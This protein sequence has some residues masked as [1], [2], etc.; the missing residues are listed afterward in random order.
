MPTCTCTINR[1]FMPQLLPCLIPMPQAPNK[2]RQ[3]IWYDLCRL[4]RLA[5]GVNSMYLFASY[6]CLIPMPQLLPCHKLP[7]PH[8]RFASKA[9]DFFNLCLSS[10]YVFL[11]CVFCFLNL[12]VF[13]LQFTKTF[14]ASTSS[15]R[16]VSSAAVLKRAFPLLLFLGLSS[17]SD[18]ELLDLCFF[19]GGVG[20]WFSCS[21]STSETGS[22]A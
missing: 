2:Y 13:P 7:L 18:F 10:L 14:H 21:S 6:P 17:L 5:K 8:T 22:K 15:S 11:F 4:I 16:T 19:G 3:P 9:P 12:P 20:S 1:L